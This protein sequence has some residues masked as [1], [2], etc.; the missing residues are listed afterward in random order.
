VH[1]TPVHTAAYDVVPLAR[2]ARPYVL[3][4]ERRRQVERVDRSRLGL[5][6]LLDISRLEAVAA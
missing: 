5:S 1:E 6:V 4:A 3:H 2:V